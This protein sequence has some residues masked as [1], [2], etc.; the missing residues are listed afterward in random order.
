[1]PDFL[2]NV[3]ATGT[4]QFAR[5][6]VSMTKGLDQSAA[7]MGSMQAQAKSLADGLG[8]VE[9]AVAKTSAAIAAMVTAVA[10]IPAVRDVA[11]KL[12]GIAAGIEKY[13]PPLGAIGIG[14]KAAHYTEEADRIEKQAEGLKTTAENLQLISSAARSA[15]VEISRVFDV[16]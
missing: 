3:K 13:L 14:I 16:L 11:A 6:T 7:A 1:M 5:E 4:E 12:P 10:K 2:L 15:K 8:V 9:R